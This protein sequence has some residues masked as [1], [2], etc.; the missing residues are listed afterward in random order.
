[1]SKTSEHVNNY[2][3]SKPFSTPDDIYIKPSNNIEHSPLPLPNYLAKKETTNDH[4][5]TET[6]CQ[7]REVPAEYLRHNNNQ[8]DQNRQN[9]LLYTHAHLTNQ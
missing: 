8:P 7:S 1:M 4:A 5:R 9:C 3:N 2:N 6:I